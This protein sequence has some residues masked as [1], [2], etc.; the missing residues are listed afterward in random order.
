MG[1]YH[2][3][4]LKTGVLLLADA[5]TWLLADVYCQLKLIGMSLKYY[6]LDSCDY[7]SSPG[8]SWDTILKDN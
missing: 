7:F 8:L 6:G 2:N 3:F 1:D 5:F 4:Y